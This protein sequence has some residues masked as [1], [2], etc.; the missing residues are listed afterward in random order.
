MFLKLLLSQI[1]TPGKELLEID[2]E[3]GVIAVDG[4]GGVVGVEEIAETDEEAVIATV[5]VVV[6]VL[7]NEEMR[8]GGEGYLKTF[9][10]GLL[11]SLSPAKHGF[12]YHSNLI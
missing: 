10:Q 1:Y 11:L 3:V 5:V 2:T 8:E 6:G 9:H 7:T 12:Y 4:E